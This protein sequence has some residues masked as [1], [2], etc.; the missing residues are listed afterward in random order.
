MA[1][2]LLL[3]PSYTREKVNTLKIYHGLTLNADAFVWLR[4]LV[5]H[6]AREILALSRLSP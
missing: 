2:N 1:S 5:A 6:H 4:E 3:F